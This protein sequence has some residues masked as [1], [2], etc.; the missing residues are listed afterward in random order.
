MVWAEKEFESLY[1]SN[2]RLNQRTVLLP[3]HMQKA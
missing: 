3:A 2:A 1:L